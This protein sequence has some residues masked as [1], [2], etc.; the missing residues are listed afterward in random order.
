M[1][2]MQNQSEA[3]SEVDRHIAE[4]EA[5]ASEQKARILRLK[6]QGADSVV[7]ENLLHM[8]E[9]AL[10]QWREYKRNILSADSENNVARL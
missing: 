6:Q 4:G 8:L 3:L 1:R 5:R 9:D 2:Q 10:E 7:A